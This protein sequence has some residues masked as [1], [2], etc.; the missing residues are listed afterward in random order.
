MDPV[1]VEREP[2]GRQEVARAG[3]GYGQRT[4]VSLLGH[5][6]FIMAR[7]TSITSYHAGL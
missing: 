7:K 4:I 2:E 5:H 6:K 3:P 1:L